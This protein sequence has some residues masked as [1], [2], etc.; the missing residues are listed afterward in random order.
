M[1]NYKIIMQKIMEQLTAYKGEVDEMAVAYMADKTKHEKELEGMEGEY[2]PK[3]ISESRRNWKPKTDYAKIIS[4]ARETHQTVVEN[5]LDELKS[6]LDHCFQIP[7]DSGFAAT[8]SAID[9][10]GLTLNNTEFKVLEGAANTYWSRRLLSHLDTSRTTPEQRTVIE[11]GEPKAV[12]GERKTPYPYVNLPDIEKIYAAFRSLKNAI[13][14]AFEG[15]CGEKYQLKDFVFPKNK[16]VEETNAQIEEQYGIQP[17]KPTV[18]PLQVTK[19]ANAARCFN[20]DCHPYT[21][22]SEIMDQLT[23]ITPKSKRKKTLTDDDRKLIDRLIDP[24][25][26]TLAKQ[27]A[28]EIAGLNQHL[29]E[30]LSLDSRYS[31]IVGKVLKGE[32]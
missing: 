11:N 29:A 16:Y 30:I 12:D 15:Y 28:A 5:C 2:T 19:M 26:P 10:L 3:F 25:F 6:Q 17:P 31:E 8:I 13:N 32:K 27:E 20:E 23:A 14:T 1:T 7:V 24:R 18:D 4:L 21:E 9:T 22:F